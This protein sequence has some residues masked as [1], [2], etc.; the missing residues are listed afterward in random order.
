MLLVILYE[1]L[2]L[3]KKP[4]HW[5]GAWLYEK[6]IDYIVWKKIKIKWPKLKQ[7]KNKNKRPWNFDK[8]SFWPC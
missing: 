4:H 3:N 1:H 8:F 6:E 2:E 5:F 7:E